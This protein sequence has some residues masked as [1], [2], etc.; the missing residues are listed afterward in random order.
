M[1]DDKKLPIVGKEETLKREKAVK[2][3]YAQLPYVAPKEFLEIVKGGFVF[4]IPIPELAPHTGRIQEILKKIGVPVLERQPVASGARGW[5]NGGNFHDFYHV[6]IKD[7]V[8]APSAKQFATLA[9]EIAKDLK[10]DV[11][12]AYS[13]KF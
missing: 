8:Y 5:E 3:I 10:V 4:G 13:I 7:V 6:H 9:K 12:K 2:E 1:P 11:E